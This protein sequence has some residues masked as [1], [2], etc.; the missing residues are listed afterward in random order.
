M[1]KRK[2]PPTSEEEE[3]LCQ[4]IVEPITCKACVAFGVDDLRAVDVIVAPPKAGEV[5]AKVVCN[6][7]CHTDIYTLGGSDPEGLFPSILG[8]EA[9]AIVESV[10]E[11]V[12]SVAPG[13]VIVPGYTPQCKGA[14]CI[15][16]QSP[17]TNLCPK[18]RS[19]QGKGVMP[20]GTSRF[21]LA[22]DGSTIYHFMGTSTFA[23][24]TV[25]AEISCAKVNPKADPHKSCLF[26]CGISTGL[27]AVWNT[28]KVEAFSSVAVFGLGAVGLAVVQAAKA[29]G[30][31]HIVGVDVNP[32]K[33]A[34]AKEL[35]CTACFNPKD[36]PGKPMQ[37]VLVGAS[38]AGWG[39]DYTFDCVRNPPARTQPR[40]RPIACGLRLDRRLRARE[41]RAAQPP[42]PPRAPASGRRARTVPRPHA[43]PVLAAR[44]EPLPRWC[45]AC[46]PQ[47]GNTDVMRSALEAAHRGWG[48]CVL[49]GV[50]AA[51][52]EIS[53]RPFQFITGRR[54][55]G[56]A[57]GQR[58]R[59]L[60]TAIAGH[61]GLLR[62]HL[63]A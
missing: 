2:A 32:S 56:T 4:P 1:S 12:T 16:C 13:D 47:T 62:A 17:K 3:L 58:Y 29:V 37:S 49:I 21:T 14:D 63:K 50:A 39:F 19:F 57:F 11:G 33:F 36:H 25:L 30:A 23:E 5:R 20:D 44:L 55:M 10:G 40:P 9:T 42:A 34:L 45:A 48:V 51:G 38:P 61:H 24:Y 52:K 53:T 31:S 7:L 26:G 41:S 15:F 18:I 46:A 6:A 59:P 8:H 60:S 28:A 27:G 22:S 43:P 35:G 54:C